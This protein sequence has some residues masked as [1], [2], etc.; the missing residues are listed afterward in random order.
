[1]ENLE[2]TKVEYPD[3]FKELVK[4]ANQNNFYV[5]IGNPK[6]KILFVGKESAITPEYINGKEL[7]SS[8]A[9]DWQKHI[10]KNTCETLEYPV[11]KNHP[12]RKGWGKNTWSKELSINKILVN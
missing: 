10:D 3:V 5:G 4:C 7:Y 9:K 12:L 1:M 8:N 6:A 2:K 11:D